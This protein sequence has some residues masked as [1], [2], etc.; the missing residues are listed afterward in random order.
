MPRKR[1]KIKRQAGRHYRFRQSELR[2]LNWFGTRNTP[3]RVSLPFQTIETAN[4]SVQDRQRS[5]FKQHRA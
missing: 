4:D 2:A 1:A 3:L 5:L